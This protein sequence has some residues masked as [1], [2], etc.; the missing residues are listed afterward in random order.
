[1][2]VALCLS[3]L[4]K[5]YDHTINSIIKFS[6][7]FEYCDIFL[8]I[9]KF[10]DKKNIQQIKKITNPKKIIYNSIN[11]KCNN[12]NMWYK[13]KLVYLA[14]KKYS[15]N[16]NVNYDYYIRCRYDMIFYN[17]YNI[18]INKMLT[19]KKSLYF[20]SEKTFLYS[21]IKGIGRKI[22]PYVPDDFFI[23]SEKIMDKYCLFFDIIKNI[24]NKCLEYRSPEI[25]FY[26]Y[27]QLNNTVIK[28]ISIYAQQYKWTKNT[29]SYSITKSFKTP[30]QHK[31]FLSQVKII[32]I[33]IIIILIVSRNWYY[34]LRSNK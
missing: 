13:I 30:I 21:I 7:S 18:S 12:L 31:Y 3:G 14:A 25:D 22:L 15:I 20:C 6:K 27:I 23:G 32:I 1:M 11:L 17:N 8:I 33:L 28:Y 10:E 24:R 5:N 19:D 29:I 2:K 16:N 4:L 9:D 26:H 34:C